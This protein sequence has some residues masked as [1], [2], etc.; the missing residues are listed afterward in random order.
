MERLDLRW[1]ERLTRRHTGTGTGAPL[2]AV[3]VHGLVSGSRE[4][5]L[6][7]LTPRER[8]RQFLAERTELVKLATQR[9]IASYLGVTAV[10]LSR[11]ATRTRLEST[12]DSEPSLAGH[13]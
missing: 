7:M 9:D 4:R 11:I 2:N 13:G 5:E 10:G 12:A 1:T 6:P 8:Y 3:V